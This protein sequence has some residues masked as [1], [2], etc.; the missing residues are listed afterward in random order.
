[1]T[2]IVTEIQR[3]SL[4][5]GPGIR[6][7]VF[8]KGCN[9]R[10][11]WCHNPETL[12]FGRELMVQLDKCI[13]CR[14]CLA[15][16]R[17]G[18]LFWGSDGTAYDRSLCSA[19]GACAEVCFCGALEM[20]GTWMTPGQ[21]MD[22]VLQD[23]DY[24]AHSGGGVTLSGGEVFCQYGFMMEILGLCRQA[25]IHT[26]V[27]TNL[28]YPFPLMEKALPLIDLVMF[29]IKLTDGEKHMEWT[30][31]SNAAILENARRVLAAGVPVI[32][33]TPIVP[34]VTDDPSIISAI[35]E[36]LRGASGLMYL[37][38]LNFNPLGG[39]KYT[40]LGMAYA[41]SGARPISAER[42]RQ[43]AE[44]ASAAGISVRVR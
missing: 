13:A 31:E 14:H 4:H 16:C 10:C 28:N 17:T 19:C 42:L 25:G 39:P 3:F 18:A 2:G 8:F 40:G 15:A 11:A 34:G 26:A 35:A 32:A 36:H 1:M 41:L 24:Y 37:E 22:E 29:D 33:R 20:S 12:A 43:L 21:V 23:A 9:M 5:D 6:T 38:L 44:S 7:S 30:G 27:E